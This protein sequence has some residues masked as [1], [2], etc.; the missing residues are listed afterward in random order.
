MRTYYNR[1]KGLE[2]KKMKNKATMMMAVGMGLAA[3]TAV[4]MMAM[5][6]KNKMK[7]AANKA[8][9]KA[10]QFASDVSQAMNSVSAR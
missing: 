8:M 9:K 2:V 6:K 5:P 7:S 10:E 3:A 4:G 1:K